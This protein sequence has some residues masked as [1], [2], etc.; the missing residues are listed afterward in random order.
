MSSLRDLQQRAYRAIVLGDDGVLPE[1]G[2][3]AAVGLEVYRNNARETFRRT[4]SSTYPVV[5]QLV[6]EQCF[7]GLANVYMREHPSRSG[8]LGAFGTELPLLLDVFYR[9]TEFAYLADLARLEAAIAAAETATDAARLDARALAAVPAREHAALRFDLHPA[10]RLVAS[11]WPVL[12]IWR[13]HQGADPDTVD[14]RAGA[15]HVL[16]TRP[17]ART[18]LRALD[19]ATFAFVRSLADDEPLADALDAGVAAGASFD[20]RSALALLVELRV[21]V[22][23]RL[24]ARGA[25]NIH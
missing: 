8:D 6:G 3:S 5:Q 10:A 12:A 19:A 14:L 18:S 1:D 2:D 4:L 25:A 21:L 24:H 23:F 13:A 11:R 16:V 15:E 17:D 9:N 7:R 22:A 20:V